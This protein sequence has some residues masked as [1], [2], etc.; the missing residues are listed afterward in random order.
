MSVP[1]RTTTGEELQEL[2]QN[3]LDCWA[4]LLHIMGGELDNN[5]LHLYLIDFKYNG[6]KWEYRDT[7]DMPVEYTL[8][9]KYGNHNPLKRL[10]VSEGFE[11]LDVFIAMDGNQDSQLASLIGK[12]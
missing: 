4:S 12:V 2:F 6:N 7:A 9:D 5:K 10:E 8:I 11:S 3:K 1:T